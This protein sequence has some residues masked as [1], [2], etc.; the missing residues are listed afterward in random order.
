MLILRHRPT[1]VQARKVTAENRD[2]IIAWIS[3]D[4]DAWAYGTRGVT[5]HDP[6][7]GGIFDAFLGD[8]IVRTAWG[9]FRKVS[10]SLIFARFEA[11]VVAVSE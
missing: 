3:Q 1:T 6:D 9:E 8:W 5:W 7:S 11:V 2:S 10:D 4:G